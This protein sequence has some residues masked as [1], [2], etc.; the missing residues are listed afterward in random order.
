MYPIFAVI[1]ARVSRFGATFFGAAR[2]FYKLLFIF[3]IL[4]TFFLYYNTFRI[5]HTLENLQFSLEQTALAYDIVDING[6]DMVLSQTVSE[7]V[8][9]ISMNAFDVANL[10]Y[11]TSIVKTGTHFQ[12]L[13]S[14]KM[15]LGAAI[16]EREKKRGFVLSVADKISRP[17]RRA[18]DYIRHIP[19]MVFRRRESGVLVLNEVEIEGLLQKIRDI[20]KTGNLEAAVLEYAELV[21]RYNGTNKLALLKLRL[22]YTYHRLGEFEKSLSLYREIVRQYYPGQEAKVADIL[23]GS[24]REKDRLIKEANGLLIEVESLSES[25]VHERQEMFLRLGMIYSQLFDLELTRLFFNRAVQA[26]PAS[27]I[28]IKAQFNLA[29]VLKQQRKFEESLNTFLSIIEEQPSEEL[30][31]D[32]RY[33]VADI[34]HSQ[35]KYEESIDLYKMLA[36]EYRYK[37]DE[38]AALCL[39]RG[40][41]SYR[42]DLN[43]RERAKELRRLMRD[44][45]RRS[46]HFGD[47]SE[48][49]ERPIGMFI[50]YFAPKATRQV[51]W[52]ATGLFCNSGYF[53]PLV[54]A[55]MVTEE[56]R[57][58]TA[59]NKWCAKN[60]PGNLGDLLFDLRGVEIDLKNERATGK[61]RITFGG[62]SVDASGEM[63]AKA[64]PDGGI[65]AAI[66]KASLNNIPIP[67]GLLN[68]YLSDFLRILNRHFPMIISDISFSENDVSVQGFMGKVMLGRL[69]GV[70]QNRFSMSTES[71]EIEDPIEQRN[72]YAWFKEKFPE[73]NFTPFPDYDVEELFQEFFTRIAL[74]AGFKLLETAKNARIDYELS[75]RTLGKFEM[76]VDR[77]RI[78]Y[79]QEHVNES[80]QEFIESEFPWYI[81]ENFLIDVAD[82]KLFFLEDGNIGFSGHIGLG[83]KEEY[84]LGVYG[85]HLLGACSVEI[86]KEHEIPKIAIKQLLIDGKPYPV[87]KLNLVI[88]TALTLLKGDYLPLKLEAVD[89]YEGGIIFKGRS[90]K[91]FLTRVFTTPYLFEIFHLTDVDL[92]VA[93]IEHFGESLP[94][95]Y[96]AHRMQY[97]AKV[98]DEGE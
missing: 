68:K 82:F 62:F 65:Q 88:E 43:D 64:L 42:Y 51:T 95:E 7:E 31:R 3:G 72:V 47:L 85:I 81:N 25:E 20:E 93:G 48:E 14:M 96:Q 59:I 16:R 17:L 13:D 77:F 9:P 19:D 44:A 97:G 30:A 26:D 37:N 55:R 87:G 63:Y 84:E 49:E 2:K 22:A 28:A 33:Q 53:G 90:P 41:D 21:L 58:N 18:L 74:F 12:E 38:V 50:T 6:L 67:T 69:E 60:L 94:P 83:Y 71:E 36:E 61:G 4:C 56:A 46:E 89:V 29:W 70:A 11:V 40:V 10:E 92:K 27:P 52:R 35:G 39:L 23:I 32:S 66:T 91:D 34:Y 78:N 54:K 73:S 8:A 15:G 75:L 98:L 76:K 80:L 86:N 5:D 24:L 57:M 45:Y 1:F 79:D